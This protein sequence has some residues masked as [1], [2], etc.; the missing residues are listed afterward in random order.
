MRNSLFLVEPGFVLVE[1][2]SSAGST[3]GG[4][5]RTL[6]TIVLGLRLDTLRGGAVTAVTTGRRTRVL[7][8]VNNF[9][10]IERAVEIRKFS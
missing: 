10:I 2:L 8:G 3:N 1:S 7:Q 6:T 5:V 9:M 4:G